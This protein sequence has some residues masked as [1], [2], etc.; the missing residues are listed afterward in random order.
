ME[1]NRTI[2]DQPGNGNS[3]TSLQQQLEKITSLLQS[4]TL[5]QKTVLTLDEVA[6]Y[7]GLSKLY[8]YKLTSRNDIPFYKP[9]GKKLVF[10]R[11]E[12]DLWLLR[13]RQSTNEEL[14][15]EAINLTTSRKK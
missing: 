9:G 10:K 4:Q 13:N 2:E 6:I 3:E 7:T 14:E 1:T 5:S 8:L 12:I 11:S 15:T